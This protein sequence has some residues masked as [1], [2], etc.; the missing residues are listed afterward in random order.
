MYQEVKMLESVKEVWIEEGMEIGVEKG[1]GIGREETAKNLLIA[2]WLSPQQIA[3][4]TGLDIAII[5]ELAESLTSG[6][7]EAGQSERIVH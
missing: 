5:N 1:I 2:R 6:E 7:D 3:E 4:A